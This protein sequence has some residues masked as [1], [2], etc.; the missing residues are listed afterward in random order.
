MASTWS[1]L[2]IELLETGANSGTWGTLTNVNLGD[3]VLGEAITGSATV[4]FPT[5]ADVT[6]TL[7]DSATTQSAR[8]LRLNITESSTGVGSVRSLILGSGCQIEKFYLINNTGT[9]AKTVKNTTGTGISVPAGKA[10]LVYN[11]GTNVVDAASY[12]TSLTL[13]AALPVASGGTGITSFG[14]GVATWLGTPS[15]ANLAAAVT[16]ETGS[17]ALVFATSPTFTTSVIGGA[18]MAVFNTTST[19]VNAFG[20]ATAVNIGAATGTLTVANTTLAA[21]AIT[22]TAG[23]T[24]A[25]ASGNSYINS[26]RASQSTGQVGINLGGGTSGTDWIIYQPTSSN[27][28]TFFGLSGNRMTLDTS[29]NLGVTGAVEPANLVNIRGAQNGNTAKV[30][31][32]RTDRSWS[33]ANETNLRFYTQAVDTVSPSTLVGEFSSTALALGVGISLTGGTSGTGYSF[34]GSA[35]ATSLTLTSGGDVGVGT[36][37]PGAKLDVVG[38]IRARG[39]ATPTLTFNDGTIEDT[40][41]ITGS[42]LQLSVPSANPITFKTTNAERMRID[43]AGRIGFGTQ[44]TTSDRLI[45]AAFTAATTSGANQYGFVLNPTYPNTVTTNL[46]NLYAGPNV[47]AGATFTN[48]FGLYLEAGNYTGSTVTNKYGLYQAGANDKNYFAG[49]VGIGDTSPLKVLTVKGSTTD[50]TVEVID[51]GA[52]DAAIMLQLTGV[53]EFTIGVDRTDSSFRIADGG[54][55]GTNDRLVIDSSGNL[56]VGTTS[57]TLGSS[58]SIFGGSAGSYESSISVAAS[59]NVPLRLYNQGTSG[60]QNFMEFRTA[61]SPVGSITYNQTVTLFNQTSDYRLKTVVGEISGQGARIDALQPIE[62]TWNSNGARTRGFLAHQFQEVYAS[63][64]TGTKDAV[65]AEGKPI[66]QGMQA[67][68]AEVIA[69]L[70]AELQDLRKRLAAAGIA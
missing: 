11:N 30:A 34:S 7:T 68:T 49:N 36:A 14:T 19:T 38:N 58:G 51:N 35:P 61:S 10:T 48:A 54:S 23:I 37:T 40:I 44:G 13:G 46:F 50:R 65:D 62:Y 33:I 2:K 12:F 5:D 55:L 28:L 6:V 18:T 4:D 56:L 66:Y 24:N 47:T 31:F 16:D 43:S 22:A 57:S 27:V 26:N 70:V 20:A 8:N 25:P 1:A 39:S 63:S 41:S 60:T 59:A 64:V 15:S 69:D 3:A 53:Q 32:T 42:A 45:D 21:K 29:G 17:G 9:G 67:G 52:N